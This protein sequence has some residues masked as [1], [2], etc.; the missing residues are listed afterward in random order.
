[1]G[2]HCFVDMPNV[3]PPTDTVELLEAKRQMAQET[4]HRLGPFRRRNEARAIAELAR[5]RRHRLQ[6]LPGQRRLPHDHRLAVNENDKL[7]RASRPSRARA[8]PAWCIRST[9][10]S[11]TC[12]LKRAFAGGKPRNHVTF[13]EV[14][15]QDDHLALGGRHPDRVAARDR[16]PPARLHTHSAGSPRAGRR[17]KAEGR[18]MS[19]AIDPK[20][21]HRPA[22]PRGARRANGFARGLRHRDPSGWPP[23]GARSPTAP[24]RSSTPTT[25]RIPSSSCAG[26]DRRLEGGARV[27][28]YDYLLAVVLTDVR[29]ARWSAHGDSR[30]CRRTP[31]D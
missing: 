11:S 12:S 20:Y 8:C 31:P 15:T 14:Y 19:A 27:P 13:S 23:S 30:G 26:A 6:D 7:Y 21:Y 28:Q 16:R 9:S 2:H 1:M 17:A 10:G 5:G 18:R 4:D 3:E 22:G 25:P 24:W 29:T